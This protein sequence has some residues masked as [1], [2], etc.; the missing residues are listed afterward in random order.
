MQTRIRKYDDGRYRAEKYIW[1]MND[2]IY[3]CGTASKDKG[4]C[5]DLLKYKLKREKK[6]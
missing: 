3:I 1:W 6:K 5:K 4:L 2:W